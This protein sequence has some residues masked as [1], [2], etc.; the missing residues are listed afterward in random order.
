VLENLKITD[1]D[2]LLIGDGSGHGW[3]IGCGWSCVI[4]DRFTLSRKLL[5][6]AANSGT[7]NIAELMAYVHAMLWFA[8]K[9]GSEP[10]KLKHGHPLNVHVITDSRVIAQQGT[11]IETGSEDVANRAL[12]MAMKAIS[13][14]GYCFHYHWVE[15]MTIELNWAAD[16]LAGKA[17]I[18]LND[19]VLED[20]Q[21][22]AD[23]N[24]PELSV[25]DLNPLT[26]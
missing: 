1:W 20:F 14:S 4:I 13:R 12:W 17:R 19:L 21:V 22:D 8:G 15:R 2:L 3:G 18:A 26:R 24:Y 25:Y 23:G 11:N 7:V 6:G 16:Q 10:R 5:F 9:H